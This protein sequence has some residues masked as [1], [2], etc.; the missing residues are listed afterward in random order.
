MSLDFPLDFLLVFLSKAPSAF[1]HSLGSV[2]PFIC[3]QSH[4]LSAILL[5]LLRDFFSLYRVFDLLLAGRYRPIAYRK[6]SVELLQF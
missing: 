1:F 6:P 5:D 2:F 4:S 3:L